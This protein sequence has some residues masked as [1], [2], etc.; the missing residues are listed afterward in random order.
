MKCNNESVMEPTDALTP[1][2][3]N[4][5]FQVHQICWKGE[6][7]VNCNRLQLQIMT[8]TTTKTPKLT[9]MTTAAAIMTKMSIRK[10][11]PLVNMTI[12]FHDGHRQVTEVWV[13]TAEFLKMPS[14]GIRSVFKLFTP[15]ISW[16]A[17]FC[18]LLMVVKEKRALFCNHRLSYGLGS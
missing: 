10:T 11:T 1:M 13:W 3:W 2:K 5:T 8:K 4:Q 15:D 14:R 12:I 7:K 17:L 18:V 6:I 16:Y 9:M